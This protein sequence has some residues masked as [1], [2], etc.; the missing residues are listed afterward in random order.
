MAQTKLGDRGIMEDYCWQVVVKTR[1]R[2]NRRFIGK[3]EVVMDAVKG[4]DEGISGVEVYK[5]YVLFYWT[6]RLI[7]HAE[8]MKVKRAIARAVMAGCKDRST[9]QLMAPGHYFTTIG[10][11]SNTR[12]AEFLIQDYDNKG[13]VQ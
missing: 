9:T 7:N 2:F 3:E 8:V 10:L 12:Y 13:K 11:P 5:N 4:V 6:G 1:A